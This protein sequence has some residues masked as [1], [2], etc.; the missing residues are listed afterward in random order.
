MLPALFGCY[1]GP[2][3]VKDVCMQRLNI[4]ISEWQ[5]RTELSPDIK[6]DFAVAFLPNTVQMLINGTGCVN[7]LFAHF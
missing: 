1:F 7:Y 2:I 6:V 3:T 5:L 4:I